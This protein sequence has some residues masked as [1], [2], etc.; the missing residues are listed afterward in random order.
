MADQASATL[1]DPADPPPARRLRRRPANGATL[2]DPT[3][4]R[5][6]RRLRR[7]PANGETLPDPTDP[8][9]ARR[10]KRRR[11]IEDLTLTAAQVEEGKQ[12]V[13]RLNEKKK[14]TD[15]HK[16]K[17]RRLMKIVK[18]MDQNGGHRFLREQPRTEDWDYPKV[19]DILKVEAEE[20]G[21]F[22]LFSTYLGSMNHKTLK[23][24]A[25]G[26]AQKVRH[27]T[28][29]KFCTALNSA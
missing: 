27:S 16:T 24:R 9:P 25:T 17:K 22:A 21:F 10:R 26:L 18:S 14:G 2:P 8:R 11:P 5:P 29:K 28:I 20:D 6:A 4:P 3:D 1:P 12:E 23:F 13:Q 7:R 19:L 15:Y